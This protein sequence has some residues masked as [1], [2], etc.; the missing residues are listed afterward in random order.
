ME[1]AKIYKDIYYRMLLTRF[2][3]E[4]LVDESKKGNTYGPLHLCLGQE[5]AGVAACAALR[6]AD[7][8]CTT[9]RG[10]AHYLGKGN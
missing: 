10:H 3:E 7:V 2:L 5:A 9:H 4:G 6:P 8:I 1:K